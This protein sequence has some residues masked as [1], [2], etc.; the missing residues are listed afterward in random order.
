MADVGLYKYIFL[1]HNIK[2]KVDKL[3]KLSTHVSYNFLITPN[4]PCRAVRT[5]DQR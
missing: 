4:F 5:H 1:G 3:K 2:Q